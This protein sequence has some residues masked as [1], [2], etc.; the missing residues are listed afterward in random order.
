M[1]RDDLNEGNWTQ[2]Y[3]TGHIG[4]CIPVHRNWWFNSFGATTSA[5]WHVEIGPSE[6]QNLGDGPLTVKLVS[7]ETTANGQ[8]TVSGGAATGI[9]S[10]TGGRHFVIQGPAI[11]EGAVRYITEHLRAEG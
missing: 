4:F 2:E 11:L 1:A 10:W 5:L 6:I 9:R 7:G 8:V 3:C